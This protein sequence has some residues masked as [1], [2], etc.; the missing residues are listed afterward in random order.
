MKVFEKTALT[1]GMV[2]LFA[3]SVAFAEAPRH[4][5]SDSFKPAYNSH[6]QM[7]KSA[8]EENG[9]KDW[10]ASVQDAWVQG[11]LEGL[12]MVND[13]LSAFDIDTQ[14]KGKVAHLSGTVQ[15]QASKDLAQEVAMSI[16]GIDG[17]KNNL[18]VQKE[19]SNEQ[20]AQDGNRSLGTIVADATI[21]A[22]VKIEL[23]ASKAL[24]RNINVDTENAV[25]TLTGT[26]QNEQRKELALQIAKNVE[27]VKDVNNKLEVTDAVA[28]R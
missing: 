22:S 13:N 25:V 3:T 18:S 15:T 8:G 28:R 21:T 1:V 10:S 17:V 27:D 5:H 19:N 26:V 16:D 20:Q 7:S 9:Q 12:Y 6:A 23:A 14:V 4:G 24:A 2:S 11:K